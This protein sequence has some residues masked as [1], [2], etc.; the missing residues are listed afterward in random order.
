MPLTS[1]NIQFQGPPGPKGPQGVAGPQG[2]AGPQGATGP[3][4]PQGPSLIPMITS[5]SNVIPGSAASPLVAT[6]YAPPFY[7]VPIGS[8]IHNL[9][10]TGS[11]F[12]ATDAAAGLVYNSLVAPGL[13][14]FTVN[15]AI[16]N[17]TNS[18]T[19]PKFLGSVV[20]PTSAGPS[21]VTSVTS[22][23]S[24]PYTILA[25]DSIVTQ[26]VSPD[27]AATQWVDNCTPFYN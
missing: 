7:N 11:A 9:N 22:A 21:C 18:I 16:I 23:V 6:S 3:E 15:F 10:V 26:I 1:T 17:A 14:G 13:G 8:V 4:G 2:I 24:V 5:G 25:G 27:A 19:S 12:N 20:I